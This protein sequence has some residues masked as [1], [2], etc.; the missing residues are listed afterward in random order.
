MPRADGPPLARLQERLFAL[1]TAPES[2]GKTLA[3]QGLGPRDLEAIVVGDGRAS[4]VERLDVYAN[5][6]FFRIR[7]V[8][9][10]YFPKLAATMGGAGFHDLVTDY[11][12]THPSGHPSLRHVGQALPA[13][14]ASSA[15]AVGRPWLG[16]LAAL[17]WARLDVFDRADVAP[18]SGEALAALAPEAFGDLG[19]RLVAASE[20]VP[21]PHAVEETWRA[22]ERGGALVEP[23]LAEPAGPLLVWRRGVAVLHR[24]LDLVEAAALAGLRGGGCTFGALCA[25]LGRDRPEDDAAGLAAA[26]LGRWL[27]DEL[28][29]GDGAVPGT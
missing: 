24:R 2:V 26:L 15:R 17:E 21:A 28:L 11:L 20:V 23:G 27:A 8:L 18:L 3:A 13:F 29:D 6:Y 25:E 14:V 16:E 12:Q 10:E 4:A 5:M 7:D 19:L 22:I 9:A 1:I